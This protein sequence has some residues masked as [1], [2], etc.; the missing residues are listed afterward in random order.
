MCKTALS[1]SFILNHFPTADK[2]VPQIS[3]I[4]LDTTQISLFSCFSGA[5]NYHKNDLTEFQIY[6]HMLFNSRFYCV[7][8]R[9]NLRYC[10]NACGILPFLLWGIILFEFRKIYQKIVFSIYYLLV[11][12]CST[13]E[14]WFLLQ[15]IKQ[16]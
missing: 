14:L 2:A 3:I 12:T 9:L 5:I 15:Q 16:C 11:L 13:H 1:N 7:F 6:L 10:Y 8:I 4:Q